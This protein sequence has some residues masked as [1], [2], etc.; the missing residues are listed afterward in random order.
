VMA[1]GLPQPSASLMMS[2]NGKPLIR[3]GY[4]EAARHIEGQHGVGLVWRGLQ[5]SYGELGRWLGF[6]CLRI[7]IHHRTGIIYRAFSTKS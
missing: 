3:L 2:S 7:K 5:W 6:Q 4:V 1:V